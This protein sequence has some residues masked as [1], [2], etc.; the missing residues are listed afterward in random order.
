MKDGHG[1]GG[2]TYQRCAPVGTMLFEALAGL[3]GDAAVE[4]VAEAVHLVGGLRE[5]DE[6][7]WP[8]CMDFLLGLCHGSDQGDLHCCERRNK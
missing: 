1:A 7:G 4:D 5:A 2:G 6:P 8:D 3:D